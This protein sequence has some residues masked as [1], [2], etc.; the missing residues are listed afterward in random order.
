MPSFPLSA[1]RHLSYWT[2]F[3]SGS[4]VKEKNIPTLILIYERQRSDENIVRRY[5]SIVIEIV[6]VVHLIIYLFA[7]CMAST[8]VLVELQSHLVTDPVTSV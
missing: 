3:Y 4:Q 1:E 7:F 8:N 5:S 2:P 6:T